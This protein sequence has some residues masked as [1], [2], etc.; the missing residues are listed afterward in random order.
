MY[1]FHL[2]EEISRWAFEI[3]CKEAPDWYIAFTNPTAG[4]WKTIRGLNRFK[5]EGT[6]YR[7]ELEETR[8]DIILVND[9]L[10]I[11]MIVEAKDT[12]KKLIAG[13]QAEK[14]V[15]VVDTLAA[16]LKRSR[17]NPYW[18]ER[19]EYPVITGLLWGAETPSSP[20]QRSLV[21]DTYHASMQ[22]Y[23]QLYKDIVIG[24]ETQRKGDGLQCYFC[25]Q[26][27]SHMP[28]VDPEILQKSL[29]LPLL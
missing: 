19:A 8:P 14:S 5:K 2:T 22:K 23:R 10:H 12:I 15:E 17:L 1:T 27:Y 29:C 28:S 26:T 16:V 9:H 18:L 13:S 20:T 7:F 21:F 24:I 3:I 4:P 25:C 6:V 11:V